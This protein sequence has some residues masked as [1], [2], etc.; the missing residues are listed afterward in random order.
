MKTRLVIALCA[1]VLLI[2]GCAVAQGIESDPPDNLPDPNII[3]TGV[4]PD[5]FPLSERCVFCHNDVYAANGT[6]YSFVEDWFNSVHGQSAVDP[7]FLAVVRRESMLLP[8]A[9]DD[10]QAVCAACH[11]PMADMAAIALNQS[12]AFLE[13]SAT[14]NSELFKLYNDGIS[15]MF[16]HQITSISTEQTT[17]FRETTLSVNL[18]QPPQGETRQLYGSRSSDIVA[19]Q[20]MI[21]SLGYSTNPSLVERSD[22]ICTICHNLFTDAFTVDGQPTGIQ[23]P[24]QTVSIEWVQSGWNWDPCQGCHMPII[25]NEGPFSNKDIPEAAQGR[26]AM[27]SFVGANAYLLQLNGGSYGSLDRGVAATLEFLQSETATLGLTSSFAESSG[28]NATLKL[29]VKLNAVVGHKFPSGFPA[30]RAWIHVEVFDEAGKLLYESGGY[31]DKGMI[32]DN[33][34]DLIPGAFEPHYLVIDQPGQ[35]QIYE[36][37]MLDSNGQATTNLLQGVVYGKDNRILPEKLDKNMLREDIAVIGDAM[38]D[39]DFLA[40][41]DITHYLINLPAGV[42]NVTIKVELL[43]QT[44]GYRFMEDLLNFPS[45]ESEALAKLVEQ[46]PNL[47]VVVASEEIKVSK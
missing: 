25:V 44:I 8:E 47:P 4:T 35:V 3:T 20:A 22:L 7:L 5:L 36:S 32:L 17:I 19:Q 18:H 45:D 31:D 1:L 29:D 14:S 26:I 11:L 46:H 13:N 16:C 38:I 2:S 27:H 30:R 28:A 24:E 37:V 12:R 15:C 43:Y 41:G 34:G 23:L 21:N 10:I 9:A 42:G 6:H 33:D 40:T 39:P